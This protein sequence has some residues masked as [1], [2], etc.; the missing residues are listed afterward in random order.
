MDRKG[1]VSL[2]Y[3]SA[4]SSLQAKRPSIRA[5]RFEKIESIGLYRK[6]DLESS[7]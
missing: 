2:G 4:F 6:A 1:A 3:N 7:F 5:K